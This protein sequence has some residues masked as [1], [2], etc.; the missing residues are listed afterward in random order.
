[1]TEIVVYKYHTTHDFHSNDDTSDFASHL[2]SFPALNCNVR[3][4][5]GNHEHLV[6]MLSELQ[7]PFSLM[8]LSKIK[9]NVDKDIIR[10][11]S[12]PGYDFISQPS[13]SNAGGAGFY[14]VPTKRRLRTQDLINFKSINTKETVC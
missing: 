13:L 11:V 8:G 10:N 6:H 5:Q 4:L 7:S 9:F 14:R 2:K 12:I 3:S 1:M